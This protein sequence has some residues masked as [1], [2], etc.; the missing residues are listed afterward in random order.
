MV[1]IPFSWS[2]PSSGFELYGEWGRTDFAPN[3]EHLITE[4][5]TTQ[6]LVIGIN[7]I[8]YKSKDRVVML[9]LEH[10]NLSAWN[11]LA[12]VWYWHS[13]AGWTQGLTYNGQP[14]GAS[15]GPGSDSQTLGLHY[16]D[17]SGMWGFKAQRIDHDRNYYYTLEGHGVSTDRFVEIH[18]GIER[19]LFLKEL[20]LYFNPVYAH[21]FNN[22]YQS[23]ED[24]PNFHFEFGA[25]YSF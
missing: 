10:A 12:S 9:S 19:L 1:S 17:N 20:T 8:L 5:E 13:W 25:S 15:I 14:L 11:Q 6:A 16:Y 2:F 24:F 7:Q 3:F 4:I 18:L 23:D 22:N 21:I